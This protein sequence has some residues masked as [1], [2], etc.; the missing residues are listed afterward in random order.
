MRPKQ[1][2]SEK[3]WQLIIP[4]ATYKS[5]PSGAE[6]MAQMVD[7]LSRKDYLLSSNPRTTKK[8]KKEHPF[9]ITIN[10]ISISRW[11]GI[12]AMFISMNIPF[13]HWFG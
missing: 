6:G 9:P 7:W 4:Q 10:F 11:E 12:I 1:Q 3:E 13:V 2:L 8:K 5:I